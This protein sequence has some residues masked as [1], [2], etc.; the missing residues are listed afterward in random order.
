MVTLQHEAVSSTSAGFEPT[1][2]KK[3]INQVTKNKKI[4]LG[5]S[6]GTLNVHLK[7]FFLQKEP[8]TDHRVSNSEQK[9]E[10]DKVG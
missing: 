2:Y 5:L 9:K 7:C 6:V 10:K 1:I 4:R 3:V 8:S